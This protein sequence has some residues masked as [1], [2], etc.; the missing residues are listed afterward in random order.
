M[1]Y[2]YLPSPPSPILRF[3]HIH[4]YNPS[5]FHCDPS[6]CLFVVVKLLQRWLAHRGR[7][8]PCTTIVLHATAG[9][10]VPGAV[11][12][13]I[14]RGLSYHYI[15]AKDGVITKCVPLSGEA[16]HAGKSSG[17]DGAS[18]NGYSVGISFANLNDGKDPYTMA[19]H[20]ACEQLIA[21]ILTQMPSIKYLT[22][23][24][25]VSWPRKTDPAK[26]DGRP[27]A[28]RLG[29]LYWRRVGV[30]GDY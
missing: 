6:V 2:L 4:T 25:Q 14:Q 17:P 21:S 11:S 26:F 13:L 18:V 29:L 30:P 24:K 23:H 10:G 5:E 9:R 8:R 7:K 19:Q 1:A 3:R 15:I 27:M 16:Y 12:T 20:L 28:Q 22:T